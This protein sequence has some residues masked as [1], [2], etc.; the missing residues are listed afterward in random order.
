MSPH[1]PRRTRTLDSSN[2][3]DIS[4]ITRLKKLSLMILQRGEHGLLSMEYIVV[5]SPLVR[6]RPSGT[7]KCIANAI[8]LYRI[9]PS[10]G[11]SI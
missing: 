3:Y 4:Y 2:L 7:K 9:V 6:I 8:M 5:P 10:I 11:I 1:C